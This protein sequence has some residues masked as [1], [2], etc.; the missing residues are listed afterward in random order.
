MAVRALSLTWAL[1]I[2]LAGAAFATAS[3]AR[4]STAETSLAQLEEQAI[5]A[6]HSEGHE[7][8]PKLRDVVARGSKNHRVHLYLGLAEREDGD[9]EQ[10]AAVLRAGLQQSGDLERELR[11]ELAVTLSWDGELA[12]AQEQ[13]EALIVRDP[14]DRVARVG[15]ARMLGWRG[16]LRQARAELTVLVEQDPDDLDARRTLAFVD[17]ADLRLADARAGYEEVLARAPDDQ[18]ARNGLDGLAKV[19]RL[20]LEAFGGYANTESVHH[21]GVGDFGLAA[22]LRASWTLLAGY[23]T[24]VTRFDDP[25]LNNSLAQ[26]HSPRIGVVANLR[27]R[28][29]FGLH[30]RALFADGAH[31]HGLTTEITVRPLDAL[32]LSAAARPGVWNDG[33]FDVLGRLGIEANLGRRFSVGASWYGYADRAR[34]RASH[35]VVARARLIVVPRWIVGG[36]GGWTFDLT[37]H[38]A[39]ALAE[40]EVKI[41]DR[42]SLLARYELLSATFVRH[43]AGFGARISF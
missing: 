6:F 37:N 35:A 11:M 5:L 18:E 39:V 32:A 4:A 7:A 9:L 12:E 34:Q 13:Y 29:Y 41:S 20:R 26:Q 30:Y 10:A 38:G 21:A 40:T 42:L 19:S 2:A 17:A 8:K 25:V 33:H 22:D 1:P 3:S 43:T 27:R 24:S 16:R 31:H 28:V 36:G 15:H 14:G 23:S